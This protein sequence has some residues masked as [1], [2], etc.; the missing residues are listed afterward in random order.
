MGFQFKRYDSSQ[1][2]DGV[3]RKLTNAMTQ[4]AHE[5]AS[6][7]RVVIATD[8]LTKRSSAR[9]GGRIETGAMVNA[10][11]SRPAK[12]SASGKS[13]TAFFGWSTQSRRA[14][15]PNAPQSVAPSRPGGEKIDVKSYF[16]LQE[17]GFETSSGTVVKGMRAHEAARRRYKEVL[18]AEWRR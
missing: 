12:K 18:E 8:T 14:N 15:P 7:M 10:V 1:V 2:T 3:R 4:A 6:E 17:W 9:G 11:E 16:D 5:A 13:Y